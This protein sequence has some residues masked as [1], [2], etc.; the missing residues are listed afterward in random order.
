MRNKLTLLFLL[1][2][3]F[4]LTSCSNNEGVVNS[5]TPE[6]EAKMGIESTQSSMDTTIDQS[7]TIK[8]NLYFYT[9]TNNNFTREVRLVARNNN[10]PLAQ[11]ALIE[12]FKGPEGSTGAVSLSNKISLKKLEISL[13]TV[14][15]Y[16]NDDAFSGLSELDQV[17][18]R[19][20]IY[21]TLNSID[22]IQY[23]NVFV[24]NKEFGYKYK[25]FGTLKKYNIDTYKS[26]FINGEASNTQT[27]EKRN[28]TL[29]F[30]DKNGV[31][32]V[33][34]VRTVDISDNSYVI[35]VVNELIKGPVDK[36]VAKGILT[37]GCGITSASVVTDNGVRTLV[38]RF[39]NLP[40][41]AENSGLKS[42]ELTYASIVY[43][44][45]GFLVDIDRVEI[46][47]GNDIVFSQTTSGK[48]YFHSKELYS[49]YL[50]DQISLYFPDAT[51]TQLY[52]I[53][54]TVFNGDSL[55]PTKILLE[56]L[57]GPNSNETSLAQPIFPEG[58]SDKDILSVQIEGDTIYVN[59]S[60][61]FYNVLSQS[62]SNEF[63]TA[64]SIVNTLCQI[65]GV[66][67]VQFLMDGQ[68]KEALI[69]KIKIYDPIYPDYGIT[70]NSY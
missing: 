44:V 53:S 57:K 40:K 21:Y 30:A 4:S 38:L 11:L 37:A 56:L 65:P 29:Y 39:K 26:E 27:V 55:D 17:K 63:I 35:S 32:I 48:S 50:G 18:A 62:N 15:V 70:N 43:S 42:E 46:Y 16:L 12:L 1:I 47:S 41:L 31:Y 10:E 36:T 68:K 6:S 34:E 51:K 59:F 69:K 20:A 33:P 49:K 19:F 5:P 3:G 25:P 54:R 8:L 9:N 14:N 64:F 24:G 13:G 61:N 22:G 45:A 58:I 2:L 60:S 52:K 67:K 23:V 66:D 7:S 28:I